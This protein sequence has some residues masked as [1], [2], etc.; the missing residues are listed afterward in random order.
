MKRFAVRLVRAYYIRPPN[1]PTFAQA[2]LGTAAFTETFAQAAQVL[3]RMLW[4][5]RKPRKSRGI[6]R[7]VCASRA[8][9]AAFT[10]TFAQ[11]AQVPRHLP[12]RLREVALGLAGNALVLARYC[13]RCLYAT[14]HDACTLL[15]KV[16]VRYCTRCLHATVHDACAI[17]HHAL[18]R[19]GVRT[20]S[21]SQSQN[22]SPVA[23]GIFFDQRRRVIR[24][25]TPPDHPI[26]HS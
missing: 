19:M 25:I 12:R 11:A 15:Y 13:T 3:R 26:D 24:K 18:R 8:N 9:T 16:I 14:V 7:D 10:E 23:A 17:T 2:A 5:L 20:Y 1:Y 22:V 21:P 6:C 4:R